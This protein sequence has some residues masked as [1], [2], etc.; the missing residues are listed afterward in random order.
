MGT[1]RSK[2]G[3]KAADL[4][5]VPAD[6]TTAETLSTKAPVSIS[7]AELDQ[8]RHEVGRLDSRVLTSLV[9]GAF[10]ILI[11]ALSPMWGTQLVAN[12]PGSVRSSLLA[13]V[14]LRTAAATSQPFE[15]DWVLFAKAVPFK[16]RELA[17][18]F[19]SLGGIAKT[20]AP[21]KDELVRLFSGMPDQMLVGK[22]MGRDEG[23]VNWT[24]SKVA[25]AVRLESVV[26]MVGPANSSTADLKVVHEADRS[27]AAGDFK[28]AIVHLEGLT[29]TAAEVVAPWVAKA[30]ARITLDETLAKIEALALDRAG[31]G[32][33]FTFN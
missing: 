22:V 31:K 5:E 3:S 17:T 8:L 25:S 28:G 19:N 13:T 10:A 32:S 23:W 1:V 9:I 33:R 16:D 15:K 12:D 27:L 29:E 2:G 11:A 7:S 6:D 18:L 30:K 14:H 21:T 26:S 20:G 4:P 24:A